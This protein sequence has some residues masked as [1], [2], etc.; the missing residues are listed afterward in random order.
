MEKARPG[1]ARNM[2]LGARIITEFLCTNRGKGKVNRIT[3]SITFWNPWI[4]TL[5]KTLKPTNLV[6]CRM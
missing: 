5:E 2:H 6:L 3:L 1:I 4:L